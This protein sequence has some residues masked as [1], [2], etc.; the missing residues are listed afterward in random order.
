MRSVYLQCGRGRSP[1]HRVAAM[2]AWP[3]PWALCG[4]RWGVAGLRGLVWQ[5]WG[6]SRTLGLVL[7][8]WGRGRSSGPRVAA[9]GR[10]RSSG[11]RVAAVR[12][13]R[14]SGHCVIAVGAWPVF[15]ATYGWCGGVAGPLHPVWQPWERGRSPGPVKPPRGR[16]QSSVPRV[17]AV[18]AWPVVWDPVAAF[19]SWPVPWASC[20]GLGGMASPLGPVWPPWERSR[21]SGPNAAAVG[22]WPV[23]SA[24]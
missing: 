22:A 14:S 24:P 1:G 6:R 20:G 7:L 15:W 5:P 21:S 12:R 13:A 2:K 4:C 8:P 23:S 11:P 9:W 17:A 16:G 19:G 3:D 10:G 18:K